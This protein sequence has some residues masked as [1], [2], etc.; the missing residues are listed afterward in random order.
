M[1][2]TFVCFNTI[3]FK[4]FK[5]LCLTVLHFM[6]FLSLIFYNVVKNKGN[7]HFHNKIVPAYNFFGAYI[8]IY[9]IQDRRQLCSKCIISLF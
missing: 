1:S 5:Y 3:Y 2:N 4:H 9:E 7:L 8:L 6:I